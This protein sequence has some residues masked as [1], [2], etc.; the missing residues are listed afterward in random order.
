MP[1]TSLTKEDLAFIQEYEQGSHD[2]T[3][4]S[5]SGC[6]TCEKYIETISLASDEE[7]S[8]LNRTMLLSNYFQ[9]EDDVLVDEDSGRE[10]MMILHEQGTITEGTFNSYYKVHYLDE[11][12]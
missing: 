6:S 8:S 9:T 1:R 3:I 11:L 5:E 4:G 2:C 12:L 10:Y 7:K